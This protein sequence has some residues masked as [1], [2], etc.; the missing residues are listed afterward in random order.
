MAVATEPKNKRMNEYV[1]YT[2]K[3]FRNK[4]NE[5]EQKTRK[6]PSLRDEFEVAFIY[7]NKLKIFKSKNAPTL[8]C[9]S[10]NKLTYT[11]HIY[12]THTI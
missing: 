2:L 5:K 7:P 3:H 9:E 4:K 8:K 1:R 6:H 12:I 10:T 11:I